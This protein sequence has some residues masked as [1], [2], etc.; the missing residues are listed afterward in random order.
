M[1]T[2]LFKIYLAVGAATCIMYCVA[3]FAGWKLPKSSGF[4]AGRG[5]GGYYS[6]WGG[7]K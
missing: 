6:S 1:Q 4:G 7:G 5:S 3:V 2:R